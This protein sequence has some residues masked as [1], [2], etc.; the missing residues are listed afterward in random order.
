M[1]IY[2]TTGVTLS[3]LAPEPA[4]QLDLFGEGNL[5]RKFEKIHESMDSLEDKF[6]KRVVYLASTHGAK[7]R[8]VKGTDSEDLDRDLLFL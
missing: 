7:M 2:R 3:S 6:G 4:R 8:K 1:K 5:A